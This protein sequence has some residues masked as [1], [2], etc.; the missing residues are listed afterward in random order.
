MEQDNIIKV[1]K[2]YPNVLISDLKPLLSYLFKTGMY[3]EFMIKMLQKNTC[4]VVRCNDKISAFN[5]LDQIQYPNYTTF[6]FNADTPRW[7][8]RFIN[9]WRLF[10]REQMKPILTKEWDSHIIR[11]LEKEHH[12]MDIDANY[13][14]NRYTLFIPAECISAVNRYV[15]KY[16]TTRLRECCRT[17]TWYNGYSRRTGKKI[18]FSINSYN[19][20]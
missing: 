15:A 9:D 1:R 11:I 10:Y 17:V 20:A 7:D 8:F 4:G 6:D 14:A 18:I 12:Y 2:L 5:L 16:F 3:D 19:D 13:D